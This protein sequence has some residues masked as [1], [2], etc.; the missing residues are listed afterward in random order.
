MIFFGHIGITVAAVDAAENALI[1][2]PGYIDYRLVIA[3]S[4]LPDIIDKFMLFFLSGAKF[5]S[6][7]IFAHSLLFSLL[8][9]ALGIAL[10]KVHHK[11]SVLILAACCFLHQLMDVMWK[12]LN[13][14]LWPVYNALLKSVPTMVTDILDMPVKSSEVI[15]GGSFWGSVVRIYTHQYIFISETAG[16]LL[17]A[18]FFAVLVRRKLVI[19]FL[20]TGR[21]RKSIDEHI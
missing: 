3:G 17:L 2:R 12:Q 13:V 15:K 9:F 4:I 21:I 7:R 19:Y 16:A 14:F 18:V 5:S 20:K 10:L 6:G 11:S 1:P 8:L